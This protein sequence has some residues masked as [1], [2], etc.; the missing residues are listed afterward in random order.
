MIT[1]LSGYTPPVPPVD[2]AL[3]E[4]Q[5]P[6]QAGLESSGQ[7]TDKQ[8]VIESLGGG[9]SELIQLTDKAEQ[10]VVDDEVLTRAIVQAEGEIDDALA[11]GGYMTPVADPAQKLR[12]L[13]TDLTVCRLYDHEITL[14]YEARCKEAHAWLNQVATGRRSVPGAVRHERGGD[15]QIRGGKRSMVFTDNYLSRMP[16]GLAL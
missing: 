2:V 6:P 5:T 11:A 13:A 1:L 14:V 10:G 9:E 4:S 8:R 15:G 3:S 16:G 12:T 7:Y